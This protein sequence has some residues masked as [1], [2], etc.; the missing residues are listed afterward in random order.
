M[1]LVAGWE[2]PVGE[3]STSGHGE[4]VSLTLKS[5]EAL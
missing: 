5:E 2:Q 4:S 1:S 3:Q